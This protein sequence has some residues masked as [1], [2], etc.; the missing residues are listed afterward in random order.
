VKD[1]GGVVANDVGEFECII[2]RGE[3]N[4]FSGEHVTV[5]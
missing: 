3:C 1:E 5:D 4:D 2:S